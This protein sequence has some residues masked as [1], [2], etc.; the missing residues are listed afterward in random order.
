LAQRAEPFSLEAVPEDVLAITAG[1]D[2][3][4]DRLEVTLLGWARD[5]TTFVLGHSV[6]WGLPEAAATWQELDD[7]LKMRFSHQLSGKIGI[8]AAAIDSGDG[9][10]MQHVYGFAFPRAARRILAIKGVDGTRDWIERSKQ[11]IY[12]LHSSN[13]VMMS[14]RR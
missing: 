5:G 7:L 10:T 9:E 1:I 14:L 12:R 11:K 4:R 2:T 3:Q 13:G 6:I 8:D